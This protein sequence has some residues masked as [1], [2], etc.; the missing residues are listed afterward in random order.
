MLQLQIIVV[1]KTP[2]LAEIVDMLIRQYAGVKS[3]L[4]VLRKCPMN[5]IPQQPCQEAG[6]VIVLSPRH[7]AGKFHFQPTFCG[8]LNSG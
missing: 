2:A 6:A 3:R 4:I 7:D 1:D 8:D 5:R